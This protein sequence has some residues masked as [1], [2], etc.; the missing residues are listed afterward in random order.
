MLRTVVA[1]VMATGRSRGTH[2]F[3]QRRP[4]DGLRQIPKLAGVNGNA[5]LGETIQCASARAIDNHDL[6]TKVWQQFWKDVFHVALSVKDK[7][8][9]N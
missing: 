5:I 4:Q 9:A 6:H 8:S 3:V 2:G 7:T 1:P